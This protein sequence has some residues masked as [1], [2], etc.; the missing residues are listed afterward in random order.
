MLTGAF[1]AGVVGSSAIRAGATPARPMIIDGNLVPPIDPDAPLDAATADAVRS[2]GLTALKASIGGADSDFAHTTK[3]IDDFDKAIALN[4][5]LFMQVKTAGDFAQAQ[6]TSRIGLIYSFEGVEM[7]RVDVDRIDHFHAR[8]VK[9]MQLSYNKPSPFASGVLS[10]QPSAGLTPLG[11]A[12]IARMNTIGVTLDLSHADEASTLAAIAAARRAPLITHAGCAAVYAHPRNKSDAVLRAIADKGGVVGIYD[13]AFLT[14]PP[15]Q[16]A[17]ADYLAHMVHAL[18]VC[19]EDHVGVGSDAFL[20]PFD[21][22]AANMADWAG[23]IAYRKAHGVSA[24]EEGRP[25]FVVGLNR[26]D[27]YQ[28]I[29][30]A[31]AGRGYKRATIDKV[32]GLNF[33]RVFAET[34]AV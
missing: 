33:R 4:P 11:R 32:L 8:G 34:W 26:P 22:S 23:Q 27:R 25:P 7:F 2:S 28:V 15:A 14:A 6:E 3:A 9:V 19:G 29:A 5:T 21:T 30:A 12:A 16:P 1:A 24:P 10:P 31:L 18:D 17:I 13:L 20:M